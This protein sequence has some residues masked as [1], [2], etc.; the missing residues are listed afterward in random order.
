VSPNGTFIVYEVDQAGQSSLW[1]REVATGSSRLLIA[2]DDVLYWN[3]TIS[4][5]GQWLYFGRRRRD[6]PPAALYRMRLAG[7][8]PQ[9]LGHIEDLSGGLAMSADG[10]R[11]AVIQNSRN[12][13]ES[14][15]TVLDAGGGTR[16][17]LATRPYSAAYWRVAWSPDGRTLA[18]VV[19]N[20]GSAGRRMHVVALGLEDGV[21]RPVTRDGMAYLGELA[22][23]SDGSGLLVVATETPPRTDQ[24]WLVSYPDGSARKMTEDA[25]R[26]AGVSL[27]ADSTSLVTRQVRARRHIW[28]A[29][30]TGTGSAIRVNAA[31]ATQLASGYIRLCWTPDDQLLYTSTASG[32][33]QIWRARPDAIHPQQLTTDGENTDPVTTPDGRVI[34]FASVRGGL[35]HL[36]RMDADGGRARQITTGGGEMKPQITPDGRFVIYNSTT[37][38]T[39]WRVPIE[40]GT[41][42]RLASGFAREP[43]I[44]PDGALIAYTFAYPEAPQQWKIAVMPADG[45]PPQKVFDRQ[46]GPFQTFELSWTPD[47]QALTYAIAKGSA[48]NIWAQPLAGGPPERLTNFT[49]DY[50]YGFAW[51]PGGTRLAVVRGDY[52]SDILLLSLRRE[53]GG[54]GPSRLP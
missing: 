12:R 45:G 33:S 17:T 21:E 51:A 14:K 48:E 44:S 50:I 6:S 20:A 27:T 30:A 10:H 16:R 39:I 53:G 19:G 49:A 46:R 37:D 8:T 28:V 2:P 41:S 43:A 47:G 31:L 13:D 35:K 40:G 34:V 22:W 52:D 29:P 18:A 38:S 24:I 9:A 25:G 15:V 11:L 3:P 32:T 7:G 36:W 4:P 54:P 5:D 1:L 42:T 26:F 23:L